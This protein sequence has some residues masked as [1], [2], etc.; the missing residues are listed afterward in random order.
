MAK[1]LE[2]KKLRE[3]YEEMVRD[4][5]EVKNNIIRGAKADF[6]TA[7]HKARKDCFGK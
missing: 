2:A 7:V 1:D 3:R 6:Y 5:A 4:A